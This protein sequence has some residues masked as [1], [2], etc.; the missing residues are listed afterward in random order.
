[1]ASYQVEI[2]AGSES[3]RNI[4]D[5]SKMLAILNECGVSWRLSV[6]SAHRHSEQLAVHCANT[7]ASAYVY[8][9]M[10]GMAAALPG[11]I[12]AELKGKRPVI[13]VPL[14]S[15]G[16]P[17]CADS[18]SSMVRLPPGTVVLVPGI[19]KAGLINAAI[20][21]VQ[22]VAEKN[23]E[24]SCKFFTVYLAKQKEK[25]PVQIPAATSDQTS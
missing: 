19:G 9:G 6:I 12:A 17:D 5:D 3:D 1:M 16:F 15:E 10:A 18:L 23:V 4:I 7:W 22:M 21:A 20:A 14:P 13:G 25:K 11:A 2:I 24:V 8:I